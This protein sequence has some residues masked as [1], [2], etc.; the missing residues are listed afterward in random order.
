[1][2]VYAYAW[3]CMYAHVWTSM[4]TYDITYTYIIHT[5]THTHAHT[6]TQAQAQTQTHLPHLVLEE[7]AAR[8]PVRVVDAEHV[9]SADEAT[10]RTS[11]RIARGTP[12]LHTCNA[13]I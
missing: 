1:M 6:H 4:H 10:L 2:H 3:M 5:H 9:L 7:V 12:L 11:L 8:R 13:C